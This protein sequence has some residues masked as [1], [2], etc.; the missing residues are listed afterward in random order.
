MPDP[1]IERRAAEPMGWVV[2]R[3]AP[4]RSS[5]AGRRRL[6][7]E[8]G[9]TL[10]ELL[11]A[12][13]LTIAVL[14]VA[15]MVVI[16][17]VRNQPQVSDRSAA[18]QQARV[19]QERLTRELRQS[20]SVETAL[21]G[22]IEFETYVRVVSCGGAPQTNASAP[23]IACR[24]AY[25]CTAGVCTRTE[26][27]PGGTGTPVTREFL[28]GIS[29][30]DVFGY[31]PNATSPEYVSTKL[32]YPAAGGDDAITLEDGVDLRNR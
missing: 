31:S 1:A 7:D 22:D 30:S 5:H 4:T 17:S 16:L 28:R 18:I 14:G 9:L 23:A 19:F 32:V 12:A 11:V 26:S 20:Y 3:P 29:N 2:V 24:V 6:G 13:T 10:V 8:R 21:P 25:Q 15:M 27:G